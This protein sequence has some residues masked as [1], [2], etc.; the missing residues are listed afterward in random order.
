LSRI[1]NETALLGQIWF[2]IMA[3]L[4][5]ALLYKS[6]FAMNEI[7]FPLWFYSGVVASE[8]ARQRRNA[9]Q[10]GRLRTHASLT[11]GAPLSANRS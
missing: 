9:R 2:V 10:P 6:V 3:I 4:S 1:P 5:F 8:A 11:A 7:A